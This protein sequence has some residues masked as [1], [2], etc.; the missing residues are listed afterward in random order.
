[1][2]SRLDS[3]KRDLRELE[4]PVVNMILNLHDQR[5]EKYYKAAL[6]A[7][8]AIRARQD[9]QHAFDLMTHAAWHQTSAEGIA[10]VIG[11]LWTYHFK[12]VSHEE[13]VP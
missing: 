3:L 4:D 6:D 1:M 13:K 7:A 9:L 12:E 5:R 11:A 8:E 10:T 2:T